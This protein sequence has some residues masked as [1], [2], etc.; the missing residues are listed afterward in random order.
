[1]KERKFKKW[2]NFLMLVIPIAFI[3]L[4]LFRLG[5]VDITNLDEI[6]MPIIELPIFSNFYDFIIGYFLDGN[7]HIFL[8]NFIYA[9]LVYYTIVKLMYFLF[10]CMWFI[11]D[12]GGD[13]I[14]S[15]RKP[16]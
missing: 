13:L 16:I 14:E 8:F 15:F 3:I 11:I 9:Y 12:L 2:L 6:I 5:A 10:D 7:T 4:P 1:M